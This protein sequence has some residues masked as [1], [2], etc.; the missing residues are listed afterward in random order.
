MLLVHFQYTM[1]ESRLYKFHKHFN[2]KDEEE[3]PHIGL[4]MR[5]P[6][7]DCFCNTMLPLITQSESCLSS[8]CVSTWY[9]LVG[10]VVFGSVRVHIIQSWM[11]IGLLL[12]KL[13]CSHPLSASGMCSIVPF[14]FLGYLA[15]IQGPLLWCWEQFRTTTGE[16]PESNPVLLPQ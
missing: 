1:V 8:F 9:W 5:Q 14:P 4:W 6:E 15:V 16:G 10:M 11:N 3:G 7:P 13:N 2:F 12:R